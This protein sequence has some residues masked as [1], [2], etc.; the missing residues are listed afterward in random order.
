MRATQLHFPTPS[1]VVKNL[2]IVNGVLWILGCVILDRWI[3]GQPLISYYFGFTPSLF[4]ENFYLW[5]IFTYMFLH[6]VSPFHILFNMVSLYFFGSELEQ[7]WGSRS[8]LIYYLVTGVGA[9]VIYLLGML[10]VALFKGEPPIGYS[11]PVIGASGAVFGL[12]LA[13]GILFSER[14]IYFFGVFPLKAK[15]FVLLIGGFEFVSLL[16]SGANNQIANLAHIGGLIT[17]YI[18]LAGW[19]KWRQKKWSVGKARRNLRLVVNKSS[20]DDEPGDGP[21]YW[22]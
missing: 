8:F 15:H 9:G 3:L 2:L 10:I 21:K 6:A 17:G 14:L 4:V 16:T 5:Q 13:Y 11:S 22:N 19:T 18:Y 20:K 12:L 1:P 7:R